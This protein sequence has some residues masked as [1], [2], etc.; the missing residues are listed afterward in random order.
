MRDPSRHTTAR[1]TAGGLGRAA[2][3]HHRL[4]P[5]QVV[6]DLLLG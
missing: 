1:L 4:E 2:A 5:P 6:A 3:L